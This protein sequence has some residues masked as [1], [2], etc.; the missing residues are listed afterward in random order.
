MVETGSSEVLKFEVNK[1]LIEELGLQ[2]TPTLR[3][4]KPSILQFSVTQTAF[5]NE[6]HVV[7]GTMIRQDVSLSQ[8]KLF[9]L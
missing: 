4:G 7:S 5:P 1:F 3:R 9:Y 2:M 8:I 6:Y